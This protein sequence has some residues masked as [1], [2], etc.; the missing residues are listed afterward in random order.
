M[1]TRRGLL[2]P[3]SVLI[4][5][6]GFVIVKGFVFKQTA[7][8]FFFR[9][10]RVLARLRVIDQWAA[11]HHQLPG[12]PGRDNNICELAFRCFSRN[13]HKKVSLQ[14]T[15]ESHESAVHFAPRGSAT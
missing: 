13:N 3:L 5:V 8:Q 14:R 15:S 1:A 2:A 7:L 10:A 4:A 11:A 9:D 6:V 12:A